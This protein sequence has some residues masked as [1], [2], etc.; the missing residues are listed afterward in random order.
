ML[1][2]HSARDRGRHRHRLRGPIADAMAW[3][4]SANEV[5]FLRRAED[6][7]EIFHRTKHGP[8]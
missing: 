1:E 4:M 2:T 5:I 7:R 3:W 6:A 8:S